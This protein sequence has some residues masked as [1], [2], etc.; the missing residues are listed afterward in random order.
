MSFKITVTDRTPTYPAAKSC[1]TPTD[2]V[3][4][5]SCNGVPRDPIAKSCDACVIRSTPEHAVPEA[6]SSLS[7]L[8]D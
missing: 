1:D 7:P 6:E 2:T 3:L 4:A 8:D 5:R